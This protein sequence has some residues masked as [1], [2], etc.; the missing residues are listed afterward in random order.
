MEEE[1]NGKIWPIS[2]CKTV[3]KSNQIIIIRN[4]RR[5]NTFD[6]F[7][8]SKWTAKKRVSEYL[9]SEDKHKKNLKCEEIIEKTDINERVHKC[10]N[11]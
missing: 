8:T 6:K 1:E 5:K 7:P 4:C 3:R 11:R 9:E 2:H 10:T